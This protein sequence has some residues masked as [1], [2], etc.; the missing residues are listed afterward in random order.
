MSKFTIADGLIKKVREYRNS[1][2]YAVP[3]GLLIVNS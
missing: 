1:V 3:A 2:T